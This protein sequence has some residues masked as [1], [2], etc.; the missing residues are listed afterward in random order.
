MLIRLVVSQIKKSVVNQ[1]P[2]KHANIFDLTAKILDGTGC[3]ITVPIMARVAL[4]VC[5]PLL[6]PLISLTADRDMY[7]E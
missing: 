6:V 1:D 3:K 4:M 2:A 5:L 7:S